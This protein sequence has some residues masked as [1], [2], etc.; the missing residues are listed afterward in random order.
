MP[1]VEDQILVCLLPQGLDWGLLVLRAAL[2][3]SMASRMP[4]LNQRPPRRA[5]R[6]LMTPRAVTLLR[7]AGARRRI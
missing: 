1:T 2:I 5:E 6:S 7:S 3:H 4:G